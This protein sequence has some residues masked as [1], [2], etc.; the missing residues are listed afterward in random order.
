MVSF[1]QP[2][3]KRIKILCEDKAFPSDRYALA[4][5]ARFHGFSEEEAIIP[6]EPREGEHCLRTED[7]LRTIEEN[8]D[9]IALVMFGGVNFYTG[10]VMA[11]EQ[12][13]KAGHE[14][15]ALVGWDLAHAFGNVELNLHDWGADFAA[16]CSYKYVNSG[17]GSIAGIFVHEKHH[18]NKD[19][20]RFEG[21]WGHEKETRFE[22]PNKFVPIKS[23][24][25]WQLSNAPVFAM[26][27]HRASLD[28][29]DQTSVKDL[30]TKTILLSG[31]LEY[32]LKYVAEQN[33]ANFEI[34]T[35][36]N[37]DERGC[38]VSVLMHGQ[39]KALFDHL[40]EQ[41]VIADWREPNVIRMAPV[42]LYNS[43][44]DVYRFG[45]ILLEATKS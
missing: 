7:V 35:P 3:G 40:M 41:G 37:W 5:Q 8:K 13:T 11:M 42:P 22:M 16:W 30:R 45:E 38:Q 6:L 44:E 4:S 9:E 32:V 14:A 36:L 29:F 33:H 19:L 43:F 39:G 15:G 31:Y 2:K 34:I 25:A 27:P 26:A 17:P 24:E 1:Y 21:W 12:I 10:Q 28:L 23:A 18:N 20:N